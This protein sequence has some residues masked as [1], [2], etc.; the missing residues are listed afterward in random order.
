MRKPGKLC[1][2]AEGVIDSEVSS[3][4]QQRRLSCETCVR[5]SELLQHARDADED[6]RELGYGAEGLCSKGTKARGKLR[7]VYK[8]FSKTVC[9]EN[10]DGN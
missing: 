5:K 4:L 6:T 7:E 8:C 1:Y 10:Q 9:L 3:C 2:T